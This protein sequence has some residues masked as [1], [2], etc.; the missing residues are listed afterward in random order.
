M[1]ITINECSEKALSLSIVGRLDSLTS[2][3]FLPKVEEAYVGGDIIIDCNELEYVSSAGLRA[4]MTLYKKIQSNNGTLRMR[5]VN[6]SVNDVLRMTNLDSVF[7][8]EK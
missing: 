6:V 5:G 8:I 2:P 3:I 4:L 1:E 7:V